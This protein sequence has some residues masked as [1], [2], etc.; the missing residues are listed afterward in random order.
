MQQYSEKKNTTLKGELDML[1]D[2][3]GPQESQGK[4]M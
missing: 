2:N 4:Y 1:V 3:K